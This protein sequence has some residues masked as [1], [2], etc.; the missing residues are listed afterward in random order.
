M[1]AVQTS[2]LNGARVQAILTAA[3]NIN[4]DHYITMVLEKIA[5]KVKGDAV[6]TE[7]YRQAA[8]KISS[9]TYYGMAL[10]AID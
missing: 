5:A 2:G 4:S 10:R 9:P 3:T 8:K 1:A 7:A 6:L